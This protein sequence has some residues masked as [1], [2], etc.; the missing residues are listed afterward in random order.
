MRR[1]VGCCSAYAELVTPSHELYNL[2]LE[3]SPII[4][5]VL[6]SSS[7][8]PSAQ[9]C[10]LGTIRCDACLIKVI[11]IP[12]TFLLYTRH[13]ALGQILHDDIP[14]FVCFP[15]LPTT[16]NNGMQ[17][18]PVRFIPSCPLRTFAP[19][20]NLVHDITKSDL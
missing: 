14:G 10:L 18:L 16:L 7:I 19:I 8:L 2:F 4:V 12:P 13:L 20:L 15:S 5:F 9:C 6:L 1:I 17:I 11:H 3:F